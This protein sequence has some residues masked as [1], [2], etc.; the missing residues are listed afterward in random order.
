MISSK[1]HAHKLDSEESRLPMYVEPMP[2]G[3]RLGAWSTLVDAERNEGV[4]PSFVW[5]GENREHP[6]LV[7]RVLLRPVRDLWFA[8]VEDN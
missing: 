2:S 1:S 4:W 5:G 3:R 8:I 7:R 6:K